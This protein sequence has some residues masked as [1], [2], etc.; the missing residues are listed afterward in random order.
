MMIKSWIWWAAGAALVAAGAGG[1]VW[2]Q[3]Q[4]PQPVLPPVA[5]APAQPAPSAAPAAP[6]AEPQVKHP[7]EDV[8]PPVEPPIA[9]AQPL[10]ALDSANAWT[11]D[12]LIALLGREAVLT[13][14]QTDDFA[15]RA[16]AT[17]DN[18]AREHASPTRWP[19]NPTAG[20]FTT[21]ERDDGEWLSPRN[22]QR[23][24]ALVKLFDSVDSK[25]AVALYARMYPLLQQAYE[26]Q[27]YPGKQ[28]NDRVVEVIDHLL[29]T[30]ALSGPAQLTLTEVKGPYKVE[31]PWVG[32][33]FADPAYESR[34]AGQKM[35]L[36]VGS[37]NAVRLKA[38]LT[39]VRRL[40]TKAP[41]PVQR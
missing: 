34:S 18:L 5:Q 33:T 22:A 17:V 4:Q 39:E 9:A 32:Y 12:A 16:V 38:K 15:R 31:R 6:A 3:R 11:T 10:P 24:A 36:R 14:L 23:Y 1:Y 27:G 25:Q 26:E 30:P 37:A 40:I 41:P 21:D 19:V 8:K 29:A 13:M 35:M 7:I 2:W 28:F 20:R